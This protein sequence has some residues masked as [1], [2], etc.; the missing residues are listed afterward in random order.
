MTTTATA[1]SRRP[2]GGVEKVQIKIIV[3]GKEIDLG[4]PRLW[5]HIENANQRNKTTRTVTD[6]KFKKA[7]MPAVNH[8]ELDFD[9]RAID[10]KDADQQ[11]FL[12]LGAD[13]NAVGN[14]KLTF[15]PRIEQ[16]IKSA[17]AIKAGSGAEVRKALEAVRKAGEGSLNLFVE[18]GGQLRK[19]VEVAPKVGD[20][21]DQGRIIRI[22]KPEAGGV[23]ATV[24]LIDEADAANWTRDLEKVIGK[25]VIVITTKDGN[26]VQLPEADLKML[27]ENANKTTIKTKSKAGEKNKGGGQE[28]RIEKRVYPLD[29]LIIQGSTAE[30][31][32]PVK[33]ADLEKTIRRV[34]LDVTAA[35]VPAKSESHIPR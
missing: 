21:T 34:Y 19:A 10:T 11:L 9:T 31:P 18:S 8:V 7:V 12:F 24:R 29:Q 6:V 32:K 17:E 23:R 27:L 3:D 13:G 33:P 5:E 1:I 35:A 22:V 2:A 26:M 4:D 16:L 25:K 20:K 28:G 15:D 30:Q 14:L